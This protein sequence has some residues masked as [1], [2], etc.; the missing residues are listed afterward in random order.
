MTFNCDQNYHLLIRVDFRFAPSQWETA[1]LCNDVS[2]WLGASLESALIDTVVFHIFQISINTLMYSWSSILFHIDLF[3]V[4]KTPTRILKHIT[5]YSQS[6]ESDLYNMHVYIIARRHGP[7]I[8]M[9]LHNRGNWWMNTYNDQPVRASDY[10]LI[11]QSPSYV[12]PF[13][14]QTKCLLA[15]ISHFYIGINV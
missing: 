7:A 14:S 13:R 8:W 6:P 4:Q 2:H 10:V 1:L 9:A 5:F 15:L 12:M 3:I 11:H